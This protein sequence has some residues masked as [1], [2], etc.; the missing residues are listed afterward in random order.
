MASKFPNSEATISDL[1]LQIV[2]GLENNPAVYPAPPISSADLNTLASTANAKKLTVTAAKAANEEAVIDKNTAYDSLVSKMKE[3]IR[4]CENT[5]GFSNEKLTLI[6]WSGRK[7]PEPTVAPGPPTVFT[8]LSEGA[9][10]ISFEWVAPNLEQGG[11]AVSYLIQRRDKGETEFGPWVQA[12][13]VFETQ[14]D[15]TDQPQGIQLEYR[16]SGVNLGGTSVPSN[17]VAAVL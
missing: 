7:T 6:G 2:D 15:L 5:V 8:I 13:F 4:Y 17:T 9:G 11:K 12:G 3:V 1:A 14:L 16:V 10:T